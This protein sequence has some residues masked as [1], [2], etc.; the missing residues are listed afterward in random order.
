M[1]RLLSKGQHQTADCVASRR[2]RVREV[3]GR[4]HRNCGHLR[5]R[6]RSEATGDRVLRRRADAAHAFSR[7][8]WADRQLGHQ[9]RG[10]KQLVWYQR[11]VWHDHD[12]EARGGSR[13][14][15]RRLGWAMRGCRNRSMHLADRERGRDRGSLRPRVPE[16]RRAAAHDHALR[17]ICPRDQPTQRHRLPPNMQ[18]VVSLGDVGYADDELRVRMGRRVLGIRAALPTG[19]R[20]PNECRRCDDPA[21]TRAVFAARDSTAT[22]EC[23]FSRRDRLGQGPGYVVPEGLVWTCAESAPTLPGLLVPRTDVRSP[24]GPSTRNPLRSLGRRLPRKEADVSDR[25]SRQ[26]VADLRG[27]RVVPPE[28]LARVAAAAGFAR[29]RTSTLRI[30][31]RT[32]RSR[33]GPRSGPD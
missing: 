6:A 28:A 30:E 7:R 33:H 12:L 26:R 32:D 24:C 22:T 14:S 10:P 21:A 13:R 25:G 31:G 15:F 20:F 23:R 11:S 17:A 8:A 3:G 1:R 16:P 2:I 5:S 29:R 9:L 19:R 18:H 4:L 27:N